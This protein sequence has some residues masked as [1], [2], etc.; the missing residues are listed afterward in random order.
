MVSGEYVLYLD[1]PL[2]PVIQLFVKLAYLTPQQLVL[3]Q[4]C[5]P[6]EF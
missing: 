2:L 4:A 5:K 3:W 1:V 6:V